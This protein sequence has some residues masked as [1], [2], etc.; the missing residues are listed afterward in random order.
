MITLLDKDING[1]D[2]VGDYSFRERRQIPRHGVIHQSDQL[3]GKFTDILLDASSMRPAINISSLLGLE[4]HKPNAFAKSDSNTNPFA[5]NG[6]KEVKQ[7]NVLKK[8]GKVPEKSIFESFLSH[9][10]LAATAFSHLEYSVAQDRLKDAAKVLEKLKV[11][12]DSMMNMRTGSYTCKDMRHETKINSL[13][14]KNSVDDSTVKDKSKIKDGEHVRGEYE[15]KHVENRRW[16]WF[17][18]ILGS[19]IIGCVIGYDVATAKT[20]RGLQ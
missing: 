4:E 19:I 17:F 9:L 16:T 13:I 15:R 3:I 1:G 18:G 8:A 2:N 6:Q 7:I 14:E 10:D 12:V 5:P 20:K 11:L